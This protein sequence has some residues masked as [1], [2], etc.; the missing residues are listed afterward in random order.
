MSHPSPDSAPQEL[1]SFLL[2]FLNLDI[3]PTE[4][5][6]MFAQHLLE[7][8]YFDATAQEYVALVMEYL[9]AFSQN[10]ARLAQQRLE[11]LQSALN[12]EMDPK[13]SLR[14]QAVH[15][16]SEKMEHL[17]LQFRKSLE[18]NQKQSLDRAMT[19]EQTENTQHVQK[20]KKYFQ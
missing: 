3:L 12:A 17:S 7:T 4:T 14:V 10:E 19:T 2:W 20:I 8:G 15:N 16:A 13:T 18:Y 11:E 9:S 6:M 1:E 5:K